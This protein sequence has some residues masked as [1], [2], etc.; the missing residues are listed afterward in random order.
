MRVLSFRNLLQDKTL[1]LSL[2]ILHFSKVPLLEV[3]KKPTDLPNP[4]Q[5]NPTHRVGSVLKA[6]WV[7]LGL[8]TKKKKKN[9]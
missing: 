8:V 5:P 6:W 7:G 2:G 1:K 9:L 4:T 3:F